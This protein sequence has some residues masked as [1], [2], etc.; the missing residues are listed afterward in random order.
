L[1]FGDL[2]ALL[3]MVAS[4]RKLAFDPERRDEDGMYPLAL[5]EGNGGRR[6]DVPQNSS[7]A[8][9]LEWLG[10]D[11][12]SYSCRCE[13]RGANGLSFT[14]ILRWLR[15]WRERNDRHL[16]KQAE[17]LPDLDPIEELARIVGEAQE[18]DA[19]DERRLDHPMP[20]GRASSYQRRRPPR[21]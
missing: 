1:D 9:I 21:R 12:R 18:R 15:R 14:M 11:G 2:A 20:S 19:D 3:W 13:R 4:L 7:V 8:N 6:I 16:V 10:C 5:T 17:P